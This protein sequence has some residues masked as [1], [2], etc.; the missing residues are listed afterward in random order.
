MERLK[1]R[2]KLQ[3]GIL[4]FVILIGL[5]FFVLYHYYDNYTD[6]EQFYSLV[7][8]NYKNPSSVEGFVNPPWTLVFVL[9]GFLPLK[10][11]NVINLLINIIILGLAIRKV[12][13]G[14][15]GILLTFTCPLFLDLARVNSIDWI[16]LLGFLL[17]TAWGLPL[18]AVKPQTLGM[19]ALIKWKKERFSWKVLTPLVTVV[20]ASFLI[21]GNWIKPHSYSFFM[22]P[23]NFSFWPLSIPLGLYVLYKAYK[24]NDEILA[25]VSTPL[26]FPYIAPYSLVGLIALLSGKHKKIALVVYIVMYWYLVVEARRMGLL[27]GLFS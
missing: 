21:W 5:A 24:E 3:I 17:P 11:S 22:K 4:A 7:A 2:W 27:N 14:W 23:W 26:F 13:G 12:S 16:P 1:T 18:I 20:I 6:W 9:H 8:P 25:A 15:V 19:S 10:I